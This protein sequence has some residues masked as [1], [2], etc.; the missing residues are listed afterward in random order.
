MSRQNNYQSTSSADDL[1]LDLEKLL[2]HDDGAAAR[3]HLQAGRWITYRDQNYPDAMVR[4]WPSGK[5]ELI[6]AD[7]LGNIFVLR[8]L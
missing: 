7:L 5:R 6:E 2:E 1:W 4:E 3:A 8:T